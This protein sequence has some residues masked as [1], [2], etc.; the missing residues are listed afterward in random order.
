MNFDLKIALRDSKTATRP[1][2]IVNPI[3]AKHLPSKPS[4]SLGIFLKL[5]KKIAS[6][7]IG[8]KVLVIG[9]AETATA[10]GAA[11]ASVIDEAVYVHTT[12][13]LNGALQTDL[14]TD[15]L[16]EHSH[17]KNQ[18]LFLQEEYRNLF[19]FD[20]I[21]FV[22]DEITTGKTILNFLKNIKYSGKIIVAALVFNGF[23]ER[24]ISNYDAS[25][26]SLKKIGYV[27]HIEIDG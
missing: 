24:L 7:T 17:A 21:I 2:V 8:E 13:D 26:F 9:F 12:R 11:V 18:S 19:Q 4:F 25:F 22:E 16:E 27:Y 14:V 20:R 1:Y 6:E 5:G 23:N 15:F 3:L 10:V